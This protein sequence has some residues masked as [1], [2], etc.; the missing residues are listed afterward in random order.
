[1]AIVLNK[2]TWTKNLFNSFYAFCYLYLF[3]Y[4]KL[5]NRLHFKLKEVLFELLRLLT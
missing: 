3:F 1:M 4:I 5:I 2:L